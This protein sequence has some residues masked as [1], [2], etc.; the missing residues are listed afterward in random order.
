MSEGLREWKHSGISR[1]QQATRDNIQK[2]TAILRSANQ[3]IASTKSYSGG[4]SFEVSNSGSNL[5]APATI[6]IEMSITGL[7][8]TQAVDSIGNDLTYILTSGSTIMD[9]ITG[10]AE[11]VSLRI[12]VEE[13]LTGTLQIATRF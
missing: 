9:S 10:I 3:V 13:N 11:G 8:W 7:N 6:N 2:T 4:M 1:T 12:V 5:S